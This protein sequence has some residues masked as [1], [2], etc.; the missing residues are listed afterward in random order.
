[1][2]IILVNYLFSSSTRF[3]GP[4]I[5]DLLLPPDPVLVPLF[6][7]LHNLH[8]LPT[9]LKICALSSHLQKKTF[10]TTASAGTKLNLQNNLR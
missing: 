5:Y 6:L 3:S 8:L 1:M 7:L 4:I 10:Q 9:V 2:H